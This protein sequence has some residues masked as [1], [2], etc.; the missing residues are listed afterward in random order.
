MHH[1]QTII[2]IYPCYREMECTKTTLQK[3]TGPQGVPFH[4]LAPRHEGA[5]VGAMIP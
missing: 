2:C 4:Q 5:A 3:A 1:V